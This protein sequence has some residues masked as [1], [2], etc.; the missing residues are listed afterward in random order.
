[1]LII[2]HYQFHDEFKNIEEFSIVFTAEET[3]AI[4]D[5]AA[6]CQ[7]TVNNVMQ[8]AWAIL[9][10]RYSGEQEVMFG[11]TVS[12]RPAEL[13]GVEEMVGL[14][15]NTLP[16]SISINSSTTVKESITELRDLTE[17]VNRNSYLG[18]TELKTLSGIEGDLPLFYSHLFLKI[19]PLMKH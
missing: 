13:P 8:L 5:F 9:L 6:S 2:S 16:L 4:Q 7:V 11:M 15:I 14:F 17:Q 12:G 1:M 18:L 3:R 19:T 10:S